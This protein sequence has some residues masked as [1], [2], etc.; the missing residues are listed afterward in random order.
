MNDEV[1]PRLSAD[2]ATLYFNYD[3]ETAGDL[4]ADVWEARRQCLDP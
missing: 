2:G 1:F 3:T 4:N